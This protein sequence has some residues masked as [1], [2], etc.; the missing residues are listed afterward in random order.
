MQISQQ[1]AKRI[2]LI[3]H[4]QVALAMC[5]VGSSVA[6]A[7]V[8]T[9]EMPVFLASF[10]RFAIAALF[11]VPLH[12][13]MSG[14][15]RLPSLKVALLLAAQ[16]FFGVFLFSL[17]MLLGLKYTSAVNAGVILGMLPAVNAL[18]SVW[19]LHERLNLRYAIGIGLS[20]LGAVLLELHSVD[21]GIGID[22]GIGNNIGLLGILLVLAAVFC[23]AMFS[24][25]GKLSG[26]SLPAISIACWVTLIG[27]LLFAPTA[28]YQAVTFDFSSVSPTVWWL[29]GYYGLGVT[30]LGFSLFYAGLA[31][32]PAVAAGIHMAFV[33]LSAMLIA[34]LILDEP[35][36]LIDAFSSL[37]VLAAVFV[38][39]LK[40]ADQ[41]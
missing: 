33:P 28:L 13:I 11:I 9:A 26:L 5:I 31:K 8:I 21:S 15:L 27:V 23:E 38:I 20:V 1:D 12:Y 18:L 19:L 22:I 4:I 14:R 30:V 3:G 10:L 29:L 39:G 2:E 25:V 32:I 35:F 6:V 34:V 24:V 37:L 40:K 41:T 16:A 7:K 17:C 36:G